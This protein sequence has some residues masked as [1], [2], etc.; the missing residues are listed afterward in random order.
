M[1]KNLF[2]NISTRLR[3]R[4]ESMENIAYDFS[5]L[6][7]TIMHSWPINILN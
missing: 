5:F 2:H 7:P 3:Q 4:F 6:D 1:I